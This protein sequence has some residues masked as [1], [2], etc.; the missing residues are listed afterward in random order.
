MIQ[1]LSILFLQKL[2]TTV[3]YLAYECKKHVL[4][5]RPDMSSYADALHELRALI[6]SNIPLDFMIKHVSNSLPSTGV[7]TRFLLSAP[8]LSIISHLYFTC[9]NEAQHVYLLQKNQFSRAKVITQ[10][11]S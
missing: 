6:S 1:P 4:V 7:S 8:Y 3:E 2:L 5:I 11:I 10:Y 9:C